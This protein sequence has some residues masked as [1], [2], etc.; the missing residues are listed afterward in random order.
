MHHK[1]YLNYILLAGVAAISPRRNYLLE[2]SYD[3][4]F[5]SWFPRF[6]KTVSTVQ[7]FSKLR[8][9]LYCI[10]SCQLG[11]EI[12]GSSNATMYDTS[13]FMQIVNTYCKKLNLTFG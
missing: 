13:T 12:D 11:F 7:K 6:P 3:V 1:K 4:E 5:V 9:G 2:L 10:N 8:F